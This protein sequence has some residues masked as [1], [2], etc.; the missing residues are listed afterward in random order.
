MLQPVTDKK[1]FDSQD[2]IY[3]IVPGFIANYQK[4]FLKTLQDSLTLHKKNICSIKFYGHQE[5]EKKLWNPDEMKAHLKK[6]FLKIRNQNPKNHIIILAHSQGS[7]ITAMSYECFDDNTKII[8]LAP[9]ILLDK[10]ILP[11]VSDINQKQI[12]LNNNPV[13]CTISKNNKKLLDKQWLNSYKNCHPEKLLFNIKQDCILIQATNDFIDQKNID[14]ILQHIPHTQ[15]I[16]IKTNH[17]FDDPEESF[18]ILEQK[19]LM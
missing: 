12:R 14:L 10:I 4:G 5:D 7:A 9:A 17:W 3:C 13:L 2:T 1:I 16:Q 11:R 18:K 6:E 19:I 15:L 8:F